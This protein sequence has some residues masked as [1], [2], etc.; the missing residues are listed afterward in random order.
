MFSPSVEA[1]LFREIEEMEAEEKMLSDRIHALQHHMAMM[2]A[3]LIRDG[4]EQARERVI[5]TLALW[6]GGRH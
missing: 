1:A 4:S 2:R 6:G 3:R 5:S